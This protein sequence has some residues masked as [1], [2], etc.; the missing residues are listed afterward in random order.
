MKPSRFL[1]HQ[2]TYKKLQEEKEL[3]GL[4]EE[5]RELKQ[6]LDRCNRQ[7][8]AMNGQLVQ[9]RKRYAEL[10]QD[11]SVREKAAEQISRLALKESNSIIENA[12]GNADMIVREAMVQARSVFI[13]ISRL[14]DQTRDMKGDIHEKLQEMD[15]ILDSFQIPEVPSMSVLAKK[16]GKSENSGEKG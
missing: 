12:R 8:T 5:N 15:R 4:R 6:Q 11:L 1:R 9:L 10:M 7:L 13:E 2:E 14:S 3:D 16:I